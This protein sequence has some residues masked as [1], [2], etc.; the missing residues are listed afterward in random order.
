MPN[1]IPAAGEAMPEIT[2]EAMI[3]RYLAAKAIVDTAKEA[4]QGTPAEAEFHASLEALQE[5]DAKPSTFDGA[6]QALRLAV[7]EVHDFDG[8]E[9]VPNLLDGVLALLETREVQRPVDPVIVAVQAYRDGNKAFEAI[10]SAD[11]HKHGGEE[12][13]IAKTYGPPLKVLKEWDAPCTSKE[14]AITALRHALEE[15]DAFSCSDSL[16][17]MTRAA[18][19]YLEGAP[20]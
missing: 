20:E 8:P 19:L 17:A 14:G 13:V 7:Q 12:A 3:V 16:T 18:L 10:P 1:T 11:H 2:L 15:C 5:T 9:M 4:T 6:L